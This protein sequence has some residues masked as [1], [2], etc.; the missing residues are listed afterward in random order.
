MSDDC[1]QSY[2]VYVAAQFY[3]EFYTLIP[4]AIVVGLGAAPMW[5]AQCTYLTR[6]GQR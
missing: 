4:A 6:L 1:V 3:P 5:S 2:S